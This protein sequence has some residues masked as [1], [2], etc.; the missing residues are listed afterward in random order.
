MWQ[1][2]PRLAI[3]PFQRR[4]LQRMTGSKDL[5]SRVMIRV[6]ILLAAA[7][8][9]SN[10]AVQRRLRVSRPTVIQWR[11]RFLAG[12]VEAILHEAPRAGRPRRIGGRVVEAIVRATRETVPHPAGRWSV[13]AM[14]AAYGVSASTVQRIWK[15]HGLLPH[16]FAPRGQVGPQDLS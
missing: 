11:A 1:P 6:R 4:D 16:V 8:G 13:R 14:A 10:G 15:A 2:A 9:A 12:G 5:S 7:E 3:N